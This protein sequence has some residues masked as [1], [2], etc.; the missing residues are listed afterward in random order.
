VKDV[1]PGQPTVE[2][3]LGVQWNVGLGQFGFKIKMKEKLSTRRGVLSVV[4]SVYDPLGFAA[5]FVLVA[6][7]LMQELC[8]KNLCWNDPIQGEYLKQW[9]NWQTQLMKIEQLY[10]PR[11]FKPLLK[12][13]MIPRLE[14]SAAVV[15]TRLDKMVRSEIDRRFHFLDR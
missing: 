2:R 15:A 11:C 10:V 7:M 12:V 6:K 8:R 3:A 4:S 14:L 13:V 5:L 9:E 1:C